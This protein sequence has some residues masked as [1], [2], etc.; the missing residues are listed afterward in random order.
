MGRRRRRLCIDLQFHADQRYFLAS[1]IRDEGIRKLHPPTR[2]MEHC[3]HRK[4]I[5][6]DNKQPITYG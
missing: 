2:A 5:A 1:V 6:G 4:T 3:P